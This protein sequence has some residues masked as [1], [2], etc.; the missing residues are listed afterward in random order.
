MDYQEVPVG[1]AMALAKNEA[2]INAF[3]MMTS[4]KKQAV[5]AKAR[6]AQTEKEMQQLVNSLTAE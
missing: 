3:A 4:E 1:F 2:A 6:N 5:W